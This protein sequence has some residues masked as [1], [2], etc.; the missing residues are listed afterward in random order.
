[1][2]GV[3]SRKIK[4]AMSSRKPRLRWSD[5]QFEHEWRQAMGNEKV[6]A[7]A[8]TGLSDKEAIP[9]LSADQKSQ[10]ILDKRDGSMVSCF[11][12]GGNHYANRFPQRKGKEGAANASN[13]SN[14][15]N[16][17]SFS[18]AGNNGRNQYRQQPEQHGQQQ[19]Y[20]TYRSPMMQP[21][22]VFPWMQ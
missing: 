13:R 11:E 4:C 17:R 6:R 20:Q 18:Q 21:M 12:C 15:N 9:M 16:K 8:L 19:Q 22:M 7:T 5:A 3:N 2:F 14:P 10:H 1:M